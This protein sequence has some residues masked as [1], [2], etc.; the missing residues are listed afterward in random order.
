[1]KNKILLGVVVIL[2]VVLIVVISFKKETNHSFFSEEENII[3]I[4]NKENKIEELNLEEYLIGVLAAEMPAS[5][6]LEALKAQAVA[7]RTYALYKI[8]KNKNQEYHILTD[9]TNQSYIT[10]EEMQT[11][12][13]NDY[14]Y[15][16][17]KITK[18]VESTKNEVMFYNGEI[19]ESFYFAMSNGKTEDAGMVFQED[20]PYIKSVPSNWDN[21]SLNN[22]LVT[23]SFKKEEFCAKLSLNTCTTINIDNINYSTSH[24][25][26]T[27]TINNQEFKGTD[28]RKQLNLRSTDFEINILNNEIKITTKGYGHGVGM[29]QY[30]ANGMAKD[31]Y[32]Y[33]EIL[34]YYYNDISIH[35]MV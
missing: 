19:I 14:E 18:A 23:T 33:Q 12:W 8:I 35:K 31:G 16:L 2:S 13:Q 27:I 11:K 10:K 32:T 30:G 26:N 25:I 20:L 28:V 22:F 1:M 15:Y 5:F 34:N 29:S 24:R 9:V 4:K 3:K 6:E 7:S 17:E 21:E